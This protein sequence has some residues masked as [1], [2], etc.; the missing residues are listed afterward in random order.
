MPLYLRLY[1]ELPYAA[2][3]VFTFSRWQLESCAFHVWIKI[4]TYFSEGPMLQATR[5]TKAFYVFFASVSLKI[6]QAGALSE[7]HYGMIVVFDVLVEF[8]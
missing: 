3:I 8:V 1:L 5:S 7:S 4:L 6:E 2:D